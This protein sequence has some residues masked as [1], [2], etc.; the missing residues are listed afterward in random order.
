MKC[1]ILAGGSGDTPAIIKEK[2]SKT[3]YEHKRWTLNVAGNSCEK[4]AIL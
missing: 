1:I 3:V 2:L 4:Y